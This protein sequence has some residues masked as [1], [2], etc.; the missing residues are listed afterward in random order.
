MAAHTDEEMLLDRIP[1]GADDLTEIFPDLGD[2]D[3]G[4]VLAGRFEVLRPLGSG[5][6][7][8]VHE[9]MDRELG[10]RVALKTLR[11]EIARDPAALARFRQEIALARQITH[12]NVCRIYDL[13]SHRRQDGTPLY[14][15]T[16]ELLEGE[17]LADRIHRDGVLSPDNLL[18]IAEQIAAGLEAAHRVGVV[19]RDLKPRNVMLVKAAEASGVRAVVADFGLAVTL[20]SSD[21]SRLTRTGQLLGTPAYMAPEQLTGDEVT[22]ATDVYALGLLLH[23]ALTGELPFE[24]T[25][26]LSG[27]LRRLA[28]PP[29][30]LRSRVPDLPRRW[31]RTVAACLRRNPEDRFPSAAA[32]AASLRG[33]PLWGLPRGR[34]R[35]RWLAGAAVL[36]L[37]LAAGAVWQWTA[38]REGSRAPAV[39]SADAAA[40]GQAEAR[41]VLIAAFDNRTGEKL[42]DGVLES[43]LRRELANSR[44]VN[45]ASRERVADTLHLMKRPVD[46]RIDAVLGREVS[47]RDEGIELL[48]TGAVEKIGSRYLLSVEVVRPEDGATVASLQEEAAGED[49]VLAAVRRLSLGIRGVLGEER[50]TIAQS[51]RRLAR[52]TTPSLRALQ[53]YTEAEAFGMSRGPRAGEEL[54]RQAVAEDPDFAS[55]HMALAG[56]IQFQGRPEADYLPHAE[57]AIDLAD[58]TPPRERYD[59]RARYFLMTGRLEDAIAAYRVVSEL[60][61]DPAAGASVFAIYAFELGRYEEAVPD[62]MRAV[63]GN[64]NSWFM[65]FQAARALTSWA[66]RPRDAAPY[67]ARATELLETLDEGD[68]EMTPIASWFASWARAFPA[69]LRWLEDDVVGMA[70]LV[71]GWAEELRSG[72]VATLG[73]EWPGFVGRLYADL[74]RLRDAEEMYRMA[75]GGGRYDLARLRGDEA[76]V[77]EELERNAGRP[78]I[79][80][81]SWAP[82]AALAI[83]LARAG[84]VEEARSVSEALAARHESPR[85]HSAGRRPT[86]AMVAAA[87]GE[88]ALAEGRA[89]EALPLLE[90]AARDLRDSGLEAYFRVCESLAALLDERGER[91]RAIALLEDASRQRGRLHPWAKPSWMEVRLQLAELYRRDGRAAEAREVV[92]ELRSLLALADPDLVLLRRL[93]ELSASL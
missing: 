93:D 87:H 65:N 38:T 45:A 72:S 77:R 62:V 67:A 86:A 73:G 53:L 31:E 33:E 70:A 64:P 4:S 27:A 84:L 15:V 69:H 71:D 90:S 22:A 74:G 68:D 51:E 83:A 79:E 80:D 81:Q 25:S 54:L 7:G 29:P 3:G 36:L 30:S 42:F 39:S 28:T 63:E 40:T 55:A 26:P 32:V 49:E 2:L 8:S 57:R 12:P 89:G 1:V 16:M 21:D 59:I 9:A 13:F 52:V 23:E 46:A 19:H 47:L 56:V 35:Q 88:L 76:I 92:D 37:A 11:Q 14:F 48:L 43:A 91:G 5:G 78:L 6:M 10:I 58:A 85:S 60:D 18:P 66:N 24:R 20:A 17:T 34:E 82:G 44:L 41:T 50:E 75:G 61:P